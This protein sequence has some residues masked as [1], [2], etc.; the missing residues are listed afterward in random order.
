MGFLTKVSRDSTSYLETCNPKC[1]TVV[2]YLV[3]D[4]ERFVALN[5]IVTRERSIAVVL[6]ALLNKVLCENGDNWR[7]QGGKKHR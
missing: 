1:I 7:V 2:G 3:L 4:R 5:S 6:I